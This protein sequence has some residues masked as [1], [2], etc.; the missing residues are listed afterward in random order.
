[1]ESTKIQRQIVGAKW[2]GFLFG[3]WENVLKLWSIIEW[4]KEIDWCVKI[5][6]KK[7]GRNMELS[8][9]IL[10]GFVLLPRVIFGFWL[11]KKNYKKL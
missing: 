9:G 7:K 8:R 1:M 6:I 5:I 2:N 4:C 3:S 11:K 10:V